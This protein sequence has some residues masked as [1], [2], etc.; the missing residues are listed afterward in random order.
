MGEG[1]PASGRRVGTG[2]S[3]E[4]YLNNPMEVAK[5]ELRTELYVHLGEA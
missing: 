3:F 5:E 2:P 1:L 4:V